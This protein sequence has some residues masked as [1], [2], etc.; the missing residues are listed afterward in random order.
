MTVS[1]R[2]KLY[3]KVG[4]PDGADGESSADPTE[5]Q[6]VGEDFVMLNWEKDAHLLPQNIEFELRIVPIDHAGIPFG[7]HGPL[8]GTDPLPPGVK[9]IH[10]CTA[11]L[12]PPPCISQI[13]FPV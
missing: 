3:I 10:V 12:C 11:P 4:M 5:S 9:L 13:S 8:D 1:T 6:G 2:D 7:N